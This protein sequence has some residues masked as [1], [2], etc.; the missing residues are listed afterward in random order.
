MGWER[1][2]LGQIKGE[3]VWWNVGCGGWGKVHKLG[4]GWEVLLMKYLIFLKQIKTFT[5]RPIQ[6]GCSKIGSLCETYK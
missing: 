5:T 4:G 1:E 2:L 6:Q 3:L